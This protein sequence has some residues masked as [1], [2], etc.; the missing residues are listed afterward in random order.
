MLNEEDES[1][2]GGEWGGR[3]RG[4][5]SYVLVTSNWIKGNTGLP[6]R[7]PTYPTEKFRSRS[8]IPRTLYDLLRSDLLRH[9]RKVWESFW[10]R[11]RLAEI[12]SYAKIHC[13]RLSGVT[14]EREQSRS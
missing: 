6:G 12:P 8:E 10:I 11:G 5:K 13:I 9:R 1:M 7:P 14:I 2:E 3:Q 4:A